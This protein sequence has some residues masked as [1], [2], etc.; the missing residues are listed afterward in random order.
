MQLALLRE[1][2]ADFATALAQGWSSGLEALYETI[3]HWQQHWPPADAH[4][5]APTLDAALANTRTRGYWQDHAYYPKE[6]ILQLAEFS[7]EM[8]NLA[9]GRLF[10]LELDLADRYSQFVYYLDEVLQEL[11]RAKSTQTIAS[12]YHDDYRMPS[13]YCTLRFPDTH[14]YFESD[15]YNAALAKLRA[16]DITG[17]ADPSRFA[18]TTKVVLNF[19]AQTEGLAGAHQKR[20]LKADYTKPAALLV[21]EYFRFLT[22]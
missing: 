17:V 2:L 1:S 7:P 3:P 19:A 21:S 10:N 8:I 12:H 20:L 6:V 5:L 13:L 4:Q 18:K 16:R 15:T 11:R 9:F 14:A 22:R